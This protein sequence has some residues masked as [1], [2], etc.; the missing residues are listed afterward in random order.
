MQVNWILTSPIRILYINIINIPNLQITDIRN[1]QSELP[2]KKKLA[3]KW[4]YVKGTESCE[5]EILSCIVKILY[6]SLPCRYRV[7]DNS[8]KGGL[9]KI[10]KYYL[11]KFY[12]Q[13]VYFPYIIS[14]CGSISE[15]T[16]I[17]FI[18]WL[19]INHCSDSIHI[20]WT[21]LIW[22]ENI[23]LTN[24]SPETKHELLGSPKQNRHYPS[25]IATYQDDNK[26]LES[27]FYTD[28][29]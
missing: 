18:Y 3:R 15:I 21:N 2:V 29:V 10:T 7:S 8:D 28:I 20:L 9:K 5:H 14:V 25:L 23:Q 13:Y 1:F 4:K 24:S 27:L 17:S 19:F 6:I 22:T 11:I 12:C 16:V 26:D